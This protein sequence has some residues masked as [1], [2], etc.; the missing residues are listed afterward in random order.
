MDPKDPG[1][2]ITDPKDPRENIIDPKNLT[3]LYQFWEGKKKNNFRSFFIIR[4]A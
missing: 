1:E 3:I 2:K 4:C